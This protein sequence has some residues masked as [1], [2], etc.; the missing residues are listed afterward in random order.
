MFTLARF[1]DDGEGGWGTV[2]GSP[3][4]SSTFLSSCPR[5]VTVCPWPLPQ[6]HIGSLFLLSLLVLWSFYLPGTPYLP[7]DPLLQCPDGGDWKIV[8]S[9]EQDQWSHRRSIP[10]SLPLTTLLSPSL[11]SSHIC[12]WWVGGALGT[13]LVYSRTSPTDFWFNGQ[14]GR[15]G[16]RKLFLYP[17][18]FSIL[19]ALRLARCLFERSPFLR[20]VAT[21]ADLDSYTLM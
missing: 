13:R 5:C 6:S 9:G 16:Y 14:R 4:S 11:L 1:D 7:L 20:L 17:G 15:R 10:P 21:K 19:M 2:L 12:P 8:T 3:S 18:M